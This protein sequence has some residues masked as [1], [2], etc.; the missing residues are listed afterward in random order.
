[1]GVEPY[2]EGAT[3]NDTSTVAEYRHDIA[4]IADDSVVQAFDRTSGADRAAFL[5]QFWTDR[6]SREL[7][8]PAERIREHYRRIQ[9][10]KRNFGLV[11]LARHYDII[12]RY[13]SGSTDFDD[14]GII[15]IRHGEP[16]ARATLTGRDLEANETWRFNR[17]DGN[18]V[19]HFV[20]REDVQDYKL[21]ESVTDLLGFAESVRMRSDI[22]S[23]TQ[24]A[25]WDDLLLSRE[26][27]APIYGRLQTAGLSSVTL[28]SQERRLGQRS[29]EIGTTTD[30]YELDYQ[31]ELH[32]Q[33]NVI[34]LGGGG[35]S[36][37]IFVT[38]AIPGAEL[39]PVPTE[40][41]NVYPIRVRVAFQN[42]RGHT[43]ATMDT[44]SY[45]LLQGAIP[46]GEHLVGKVMLPVPA[47]YFGYT[48]ALQEGEN[49][50]VVFPTDSIR[51]QRL[52]GTEFAVS[53]LAL[54]WRNANLRWVSTTGDTVFFNPTNAYR[55]GSEMELYYE[56]YGLERGEKYR[57]EL[58]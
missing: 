26:H 44:T 40:Q 42:Q 23:T 21:V 18:L 3:I 36:N 22:S 35:D 47:G 50:G 20:A 10:A 34:A 31:E 6:A 7:R 54:G 8:T 13:R 28:Q 37:R 16:D 51:V 1:Q 52:N 5:R 39:H 29:I 4:L 19:F 58:V 43:V 45:F 33:M 24:R 9:Y 14:R 46:P 48:M 56:V 38:Y 11:S 12:E 25:A 55:D 15:Y 49:L 32:P 2:F 53:D 17:A 41:G 30:S 57:T 27:I